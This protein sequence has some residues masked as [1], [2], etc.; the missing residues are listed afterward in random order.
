MLICSTAC[1]RF[2]STRRITPTAASCTLIPSGSP[3][4]ARS[5]ASARSRSSDTTPPAYGPGASRPSTSCASVTVGSS[6]PRPYAAGPGTAPAPRGPA[7]SSPRSIGARDGAAAGPDGVDVHR[8]RH[9]IVAADHEPVGDRDPP[10]RAQHDVARRAADLHRDEVVESGRGS[11]VVERAHPARRS[12]Q[13]EVHRA[14]GYLTD[15]DRPSVS[16]AARAGPARVPAR[17]GVRRGLAGSGRL[18]GRCTR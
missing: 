11:E 10:A 1:S 4:R 2:C 7:N 15:R 5:A 8:S 14:V 17:A 16:I 3:T 6:P 13:H 12:R 18:S 9:E